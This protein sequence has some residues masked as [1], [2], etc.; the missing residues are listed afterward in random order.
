MYVCNILG[1][2]RQILVY[3]LF[4][5]PVAILN[6][7]RNMYNCFPKYKLWRI[8]HCYLC[9][10]N[11]VLITVWQHKSSTCRTQHELVNFEWKSHGCLLLCGKPKLFFTSRLFLFDVYYFVF[12][13]FREIYIQVLMLKIYVH[14]FFIIN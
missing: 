12:N 6:K 11:L 1:N 14:I 9:Y 10:V 5:L 3:Q 8:V 13:C 2:L 7:H 4:N